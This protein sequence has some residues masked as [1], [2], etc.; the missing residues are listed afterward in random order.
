MEAEKGRMRL[1]SQTTKGKEYGV[2]FS[3]HFPLLGAVMARVPIE[4]VQPCCSI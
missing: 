1:T 3:E 2:Q 4:E